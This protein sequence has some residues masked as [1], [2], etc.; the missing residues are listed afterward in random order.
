MAHSDRALQ[1]PPCSNDITYLNKWPLGQCAV[2]LRVCLVKRRIG[3]RF[4][5]CGTLNNS[6]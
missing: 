6:C 4:A 3:I 2:V 5:K 1:N